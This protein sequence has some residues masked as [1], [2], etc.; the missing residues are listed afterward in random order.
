M[1]EILKE[2]LIN[3]AEALEILKA[4]SKEKELGY[5]QKNALEYLK[6]YTN[7]TEKKA[8]ELTQKLTELGKLTERQI[9]SI[10]NL[11]PKDRDDLRVILEKDYKNLS[12]EEKNLILDNISKISK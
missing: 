9:I 5:E 2:K 4:R 7:I 6:K 8:Q 3:N 12:E 10:V 1:D 11:L